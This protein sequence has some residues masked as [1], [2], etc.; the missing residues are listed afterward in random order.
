MQMFQITFEESGADID[1]SA[2]S[3]ISECS[4]QVNQTD[5]ICTEPLRM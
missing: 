3:V 4:S 5:T 2:T 1:M